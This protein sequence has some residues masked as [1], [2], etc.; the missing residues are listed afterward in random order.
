M[1]RGFVLILLLFA[2]LLTVYG[3]AT[4]GTTGLLNIPSANMHEDGT[5]IAGGNYLPEV[6]TPERFS[7]GTGNY[8]FNVTFLPFLEIT[9]RLTLL[10]SDHNNG[11]YTEQD[12]GFGGRLRLL[13]EGKYRPALVVAADDFYTQSKGGGNRTF[14]VLYGVTSKIINWKGNS[15]G[16]TIGYGLDAYK[17]NHLDG[18]FGGIALS[19]TFLKQLRLMADYDTHSVNIGGSLMLF[20]HLYLHAFFNDYRYFVAGGAIH[21]KLY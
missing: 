7:Y 11:R 8:Y 9:Y 1:K 3:Q 15:L 21:I 6:I 4:S 17:K 2:E 18:V 13:K 16:F 19:P 20:K 14:G 5:F 12:R 10:K